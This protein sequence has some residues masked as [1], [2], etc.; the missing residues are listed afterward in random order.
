MFLSK[1]NLFDRDMTIA[2]KQAIIDKLCTVLDLC[3]N[4]ITS[5]GFAI[6]ANTLHNNKTLEKLTLS[7]NLASDKGIG[8]IAHSIDFSYKK[9]T[10][11]SLQWYYG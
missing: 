9:H 3:Q 4:N 6:L 11:H 2:V 8:H 7:D 5:E 1:L 10:Y